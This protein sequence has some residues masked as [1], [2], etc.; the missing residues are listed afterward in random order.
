MHNPKILIILFVAFFLSPLLGRG[1]CDAKYEYSVRETA[2]NQY[3]I[4]I[5][6]DQFAGPVSIVLQDLYTGEKINEKDVEITNRVIEVFQ[7][8]KPS[9]YIIYIKK[10]GCDKA[11][12]LGGVEGIKIGN[13]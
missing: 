7:N 5:K 8:L 6:A 4:E 1:Q 12:S 2:P 10:K 9:L 13:P 11:V 3:S